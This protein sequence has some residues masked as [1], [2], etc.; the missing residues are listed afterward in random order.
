MAPMFQNGISQNAKC[1]IK[2]GYHRDSHKLTC[3]LEVSEN[4]IEHFQELLLK[5]NN[6]QKSVSI[7]IIDSKVF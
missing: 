5:S 2:D 7:Y 1:T 6:L 3:L 4:L